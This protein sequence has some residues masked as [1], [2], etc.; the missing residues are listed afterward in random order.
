[1]VFAEILAQVDLG[2][3]DSTLVEFVRMDLA[4]A[5]AVRVA[6]ALV[7]VVVNMTRVDSTDMNMA[8][9][10]VIDVD[11]H[12]VGL[13]VDVAYIDSVCRV[14]LMWIGIAKWT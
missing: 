1:M 4:H 7:R 13:I 12:L 11:M 8:L 10:H 6:M 14:R 9:V 5:Y 3:V 2:C